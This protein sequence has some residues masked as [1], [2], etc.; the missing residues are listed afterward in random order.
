M[1]VPNRASAVATFTV[2]AA[3]GKVLGGARLSAVPAPHARAGDRDRARE[4]QDPRLAVSLR[5]DDDHRR[6]GRDGAALHGA[7]RRRQLRRGRPGRGRRRDGAGSSRRGPGRRWPGRWP[8]ATTTRSGGAS[9]TRG[10]G[11]R[12]ARPSWSGSSTSDDCSR[13]ARST[14]SCCSRRRSRS[15]TS[16]RASCSGPSRWCTR[17]SSTCSCRLVFIGAAQ[18]AAAGVRRQ[19]AALGARRR[20]DLP[21]RVPRR[22]RPL[23]LERD[24]RRLRGRRRGRP[25][26]QRRHAVR[27]LPDARRCAVRDPLLRRHLAGLPAGRSAATAARARSSSATPTAR[28]TTPPTCRRSRSRA[29]R[30]CG[31]TCRRRT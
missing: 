20:G 21:H 13:G 28:S 11:S 23:R 8:A 22:A 10:S 17:H 6:R 26:D 4:S 31:T 14:S 1:H 3:T 16:T 2:D 27:H 9:T 18:R 19:P 15:R 7:L 5:H 25:P 24:R 30:A 12:C 29:G